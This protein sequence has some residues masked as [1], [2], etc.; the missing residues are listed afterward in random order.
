MCRVRNR[1]GRTAVDR[2]DSERG[3]ITGD[4][5]LWAA[6]GLLLLACFNGALLYRGKQVISAA[7]QDGARA[8]AVEWG[9]AGAARW[10]AGHTLDFA[11]FISNESITINET[12]ERIEVAVIAQVDL[13]FLGWSQTFASYA[14]APKERVV[15]AS[16]R[17]GS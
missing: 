12:E 6:F 5:A 1:S 15:T 8:G 3:G 4:V 9:D 13:P 7:A 11:P 14:D 17:P 10:R 16:E 2:D